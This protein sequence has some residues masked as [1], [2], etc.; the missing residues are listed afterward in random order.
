MV[1]KEYM[2][3]L[4]SKIT[5]LLFT[6]LLIPGFISFYM[7]YGEKQEFVRQMQ[8]GAEDLNIHAVKNLIENYKG[9]T[10]LTNFLFRS[11]FYQVFIIILFIGIGIFMGSLI[12]TQ[13]EE[14]YGNLIVTR[15]TYRSYL[16]NIMKAQSLYLL[17]LL[18]GVFLIYIIGAFSIGG[19]STNFDGI[20]GYEGGFAT[21]IF[22]V[23]VHM[24]LLIIYTITVNNVTLLSPLMTDNK[25]V[26]QGVPIMFFLV[27][28]MV[29]GSTVANLSGLLGSIISLFIPFLTLNITYEYIMFELSV[30]ELLFSLSGFFLLI[31]AFFL[32]YRA[33]IKKFSED[34]I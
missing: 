16:T 20:G 30:F 31:G 21:I 28:P 11:D 5:P 1:K 18:S 8:I 27:I 34:Y 17:T 33:N 9:M 10:F 12:Q 22:L 24:T 19:W 14:G 3:Y 7:S 23:F 29:L 26:I 4:K 15:T 6:F 2:R 13:K 32:L 25:Y